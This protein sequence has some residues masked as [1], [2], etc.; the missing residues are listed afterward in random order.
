MEGFFSLELEPGK[1]RLVFQYVGYQSEIR[2][3][4]V[5][6]GRSVQ[7]KVILKEAA[8][9]LST[10]EVRANAE[11]PAYPII[12]KAIAKREFNYRQI[13]S[14]VCDVYIKGTVKILKAPEK[15]LGQEVGDLDGN[16]DT[17]RQGIVY[18]SESVSKLYFKQPGKMKEVMVS[19]KVS[20]NNQGFSFNSATEMNV[21]LYDNFAVFGRN[22]I[23]PIA[24]AALNYYRYRLHGAFM[25][26]Q[27][28]LI[29]KI[30]VIPKNP[31]D[32]VYSGFIYI[33]DQLWNIQGA[34][35]MV[36]GR[37][38]QLQAVDSLMIR[39]VHVPVKG[40]DVWQLFSQSYA[41][42]G[43]L[44]GFVF[45]GNFS[46]VYRNYQ[47]DIPLED[48]FFGNV[49]MKV[50]PG[51]NERDSF[52][53]SQT[54][55][56]PLTEEESKDYIRKDSIRLVR[57]SKPFLDS[58]DLA[59][60]KPKVGD[61]L[62]GYRFQNSWKRYSFTLESPINTIQFNLVQGM[63][64]NAGL[65]FEKSFDE[66]NNRRLVLKS[67]LNYGLADNQFRASGEAEWRPRPKIFERISLA[68]GKRLV[69]F[70][71]SEPISASLNTAEILFNR[72][73][74]ARFYDKCF[75]RLDYRRELFNGF[76]VYP[77][78]QY[79]RRTMVSN[80]SDYSFFHRD[81]RILDSNL[82][83]HPEIDGAAILPQES[84]ALQAGLSIRIRPGQKYMDY[85]DRK[86]SMGSKYPD[87][88]IHYR[89]GIP[90][91]SGQAEGLRSDVSFDRFSASVVMNEWTL[92]L[93]GV[94]SFRLEG[95]FFPASS[96]L[97]FYDYRHF[98]GNQT[99]LGNPAR[100]LFS[101]KMLEYYSSSTDEYWLEAHWE[102]NFKG[103]ITDKIPGLKKLD[104][105]LIA[106]FNF[107]YT[108]RQKDYL[109]LSLGFGNIGAGIAKFLRFDVVSSL[110]QGQYAGTGYLVGINLP[111]GDIDLS[112]L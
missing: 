103:A 8:I 18:L 64:F 100:Y 21:N 2:E 66:N 60:N 28:F 49:V 78:L 24:D 50:E 109:E 75:L 15:I 37:S 52:Y 69:Q 7:L 36:T 34:G 99:S 14:S 108:P 105:N 59:E 26:E 35:L 101:F 16:L 31:E 81:D 17:S 83:V 23:S 72:R 53:W 25:D 84:H 112:S 102:H 55:P 92:G 54:R 110:R 70:N 58:V 88:W 9:D 89:K 104:W 82:P 91:R 79:A 61:L 111:F 42:Q 63:H 39:Q 12:R 93:A 97:L 11:D 20:G 45:G 41:V 40:R 32:P 87:F 29:Y 6:R 46:A 33:V 95:G 62:T 27:G 47:L 10:V 22:V 80:N 13:K 71:E 90:F 19:S 4:E 96:K 77:S 86:F 106:G 57:T 3:V 67:L 44:F 1:Y 48:K 51:S 73:N 65:G 74:Y 76:M 85:P 98:L 30:E 38:S 94:M 68:G 43:G 107:L 5:S 56:I